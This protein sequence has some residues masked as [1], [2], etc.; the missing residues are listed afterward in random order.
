[1]RE[2]KIFFYLSTFPSSHH[3]LS[4]H[5]FTPQTIRILKVFGCHNYKELLMEVLGSGMERGELLIELVPKETAAT[6]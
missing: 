1:M 2:I 6:S 5:F 3:F 4:S